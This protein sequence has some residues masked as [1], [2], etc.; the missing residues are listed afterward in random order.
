MGSG[1]R[2]AKPSLPQL[3][4]TDIPHMPKTS[5]G[6]SITPFAPPNERR[7]LSPRRETIVP[8]PSMD[9]APNVIIK[10]KH[11]EADIACF[12]SLLHVTRFRA[13]QLEFKKDVASGSG[14]PNGAF[15]WIKPL[16]FLR[17]FKG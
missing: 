1:T 10:Q 6:P 7:P 16:F 5:I 13:W 9:K 14:R 8:K 4:F 2:A 3:E 17:K 11:K 15:A 12:Q